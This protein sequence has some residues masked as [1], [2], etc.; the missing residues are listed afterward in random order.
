MRPPQALTSKFEG[1]AR[2]TRFLT[3]PN[4]KA[5]AVASVYLPWAGDWRPLSFTYTAGVG[6][7]RY[8][9][10]LYALA[11]REHPLDVERRVQDAWLFILEHAHCHARSSLEARQWILLMGYRALIAPGAQ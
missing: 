8:A 7:R 9:R 5:A 4:G 6:L 10:D 11:G 3:L 1:T 2:H